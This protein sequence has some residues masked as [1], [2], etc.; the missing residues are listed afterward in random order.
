MSAPAASF[1]ADSLRVASWTAVSRVT[2]LARAVVVAAVLG[3][4]YLGSVFQATYVLPAL[5]YQMLVGSLFVALLVPALVRAVDLGDAC[6]EQRIAG[7]FMTVACLVFAAVALAAV[8]AA[9]LLLALFTAG[10]A[11]PAVAAEQRRTGWILLALMMP[12]VVLFGVAGTGAAVMNAHG[13][14]AFAAGAPALE[15]VGVLATLGAAAVLF[16]TDHDIGSAPTSELVLLGAGATASVAMHAGAQWCGALRVG[17]LLRPFAGWRDARVRAILGRA[18]PSLGVAGLDSARQLAALPVANR[19][20]GGVVAF[21]VAVNFANLP[22]ALAAKPVAT[23]LLPRLARLFEYRARDLARDE[24][25]R[26][27]ALACFVTLPAA[28]AYAV[29]AEPL[30]RAIAYGEMATPAGIAAVAVCLAA[31]APGVLG[32]GAFYVA[33]SACFAMRDA[34]SPLRSTIVRTAVALCG[35]AVACL[36]AP[37]TGVLVALALGVSAGHLAGAFH[38]ERAF[39][40][41]L[42]P[43]GERLAPS[44]R[45]TLA[46]A[47]LAVGPAYLVATELPELAGVA[48]ACVLGVLVFAA[49]EGLLGSPELRW[50]VGRR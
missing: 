19:V 43:G 9:P 30:S 40:A 6:D 41:V 42:P 13:R 22:V 44:L 28:V 50:V 3:P 14:F 25:V 20:P 21:Q 29:L 48:A 2:G 38:L 31:L 34:R 47:L 35:M 12:Q 33:A 37:G 16:G 8:A 23:A 45:R 18:V 26:G 11:D 46:G 27:L 24:F 49:V 5:T 1:A 32:E 15:N 4:T 36:L 10:V 39:R 7:G 17:V